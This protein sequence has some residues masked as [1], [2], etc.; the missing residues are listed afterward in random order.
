[1]PDGKG[2][3]VSVDFGG[4][5]LDPEVERVRW[6]SGS[7]IEAERSNADG[8]LE[9]ELT[10]TLFW[11]EKGS[12]PLR[13]RK[14]LKLRYSDGDSGE[15]IEVVGWS[16]QVQSEAADS[17]NRLIPRKFLELFSKSQRRALTNDEENL[18]SEICNSVDYRSFSNR[19]ASLRYR[20]AKLVKKHPI[21]SVEFADGSKETLN[22]DLLHILDVLEVGDWFSAMWRIGATGET[23]NIERLEIVP[24]PQTL[25]EGFWETDE[26]SE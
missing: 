26:S 19:R 14:P 5:A 25:P 22:R 17:L 15:M 10:T 13:V 24:D 11:V 9:I 8:A 21:L 2:V 23:V 1:M 7:Y 4:M 16:I 3:D 12:V 18:F 6:S 20:E